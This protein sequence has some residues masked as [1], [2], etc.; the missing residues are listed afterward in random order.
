MLLMKLNLILPIKKHL[1]VQ[2]VTKYQVW[3][4]WKFWPLFS[5]RGSG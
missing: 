4:P 1:V 5:M 2:P 3:N